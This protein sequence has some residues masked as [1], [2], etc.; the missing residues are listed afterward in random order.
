M[1]T[2]PRHH[3]VRRP[4][5]TPQGATP[6]RARPRCPGCGAAVGEQHDRVCDVA[7]CRATG[8]QWMACD[9]F[10]AGAT[11]SGVTVTDVT[12]AAVVAHE[13]DAWTGRWPGEEDCERLGFLAR[14]VPGRGWVTCAADDPGA[15]PDFDRLHA[16]ARWD[17]A[18][19]RWVA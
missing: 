16:E 10:G 7:R 1:T 15:E 12:G 3:P 8:M 4:G 19:G 14:F 5:S 9:V 6:R 11:E 17:T 18:R 2:A 13:P